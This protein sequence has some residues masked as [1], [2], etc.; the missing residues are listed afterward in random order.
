MVLRRKLLT[1][2]LVA[3][4]TLAGSACGG[5]DGDGDY[6]DHVAAPAATD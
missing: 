3:L 4:L 2:L 5:D 1:A 6:A